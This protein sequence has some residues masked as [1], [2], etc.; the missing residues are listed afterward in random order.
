MTKTKF[1]LV[2]IL[3]FV[4]GFFLHPFYERYTAQA[5]TINLSSLGVQDRLG[6]S[7]YEFIDPLLA[8]E[9]ADKK[10]I[11]EFQPFNEILQK[12]VQTEINQ[13]NAN[14]ISIYF[15]GMTSGRW[16][17]YHETDIYPG[18][19]LIKIPFLI[20]YYQMAQNHPEILNEMLTYK[21]DFDQSA[22][23]KISPAKK[24]EEG[25]AYSISELIYRMIVYSGNNST[26][27]LMHR[28]DRSYL[29]TVFDD[30]NIPKDQ[31]VN[32]Q[33]LVTT[34]TF[35]YFFRVL[36]NATYLNRTMSEKALKVLTEADFKDGLVAGVPEKIKV[37]HKFGEHTQQYPNGAVLSSDLHDCGIIYHAKHPYFL[38]V[39]TEG[40][41]QEALKG[42]IARI[43]KQAYDF[44]DKPAY[45]SP[46]IS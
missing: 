13:G 12:Q 1:I 4:S 26:V 31:D 18:G 9:V 17:G 2:A 35:A 39:M 25:K 14:K 22:G 10:D 19:S 30:L 32:R 20:A 45:P 28:L 24:I 15:R 5:P 42:V 21:G 3:F 8:C 27:L 11:L 33:W 41:S 40:S 23:Q 16:A 36:Y 6:R 34:K 43:S 46:T 37:A 29:N 44:V 7:K 38:C